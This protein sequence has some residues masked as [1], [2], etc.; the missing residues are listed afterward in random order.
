MRKVG[1][2]R[3]FVYFW[4]VVSGP[5]FR[6]IIIISMLSWSFCVFVSSEHTC[7]AYRTICDLEFCD[8]KFQR[9]LNFQPLSICDVNSTRRPLRMMPTYLVIPEIKSPQNWVSLVSLRAC[10][11][12]PLK[13]Q[14][15]S[16]NYP[17]LQFANVMEWHA[18]AR[19]LWLP[20]SGIRHRWTNMN[21]PKT[22]QIVTIGASF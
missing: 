8:F 12:W 4:L 15:L 14:C 16:R 18:Y 1:F 6:F 3:M 7:I 5:R 9:P 2:L 22:V 10:I 13:F 19:T 11:I 21:H 20:S 17:P